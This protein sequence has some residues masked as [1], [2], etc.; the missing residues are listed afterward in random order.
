MNVIVALTV[1]AVTSVAL[2]P[3]ATAARR[4][5]LDAARRATEQVSFQGVI[6]VQWRDGDATR[7]EQLTI[8]DT[9]GSLFVRGGTS[10]M[11]VPG[12]ERLIQHGG[13]WD[14]LWPAGL[15]ARS[16]PDSDAKYAAVPAG[17]LP[18]AGRPTNVL[19]VR[20]RETVRERIY[21]DTATGLLL[22]RDQF[23]SSGATDRKVEF[24]MLTIGAPARPAERPALAVD[25]AVRPVAALNQIPTPLAPA[26]LPDGYRRLG[27]YRDAGVLHLLY[28]DG[29]YDVSLFQQSG[30]LDRSKLPSGGATWST[31]PSDNGNTSGRI[32]AWPGGHVVV[33]QAG[34]SVLTMVSDA[35]VDQLLR[36][37][38]SVRAGNPSPSLLSRLRQAA[39]ALVAPLSD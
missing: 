17:Q 1:V 4:G 20:E 23:D 29:L 30:R 38:G 32:Y 8:E 19:E 36:A 10:V 26:A 28:S 35:P 5:P 2:A 6:E 15:E 14:V 34:G 22:R 39:R 33:W 24:K 21:L 3:P 16:R 13:T 7:R 11:A 12:Q 37:A 18:V 31:Y 25:D 9:S 27:V